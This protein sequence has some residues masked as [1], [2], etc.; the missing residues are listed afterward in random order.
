[1]GPRLGAVAV[2]V[3]LD[4]MGS[5]G[6]W[7]TASLAA[8]F[9][10]GPLAPALILFLGLAQTTYAAFVAGCIAKM[11]YV[12]YGLA[13]GVIGLVI[14]LSLELKPDD[15]LPGW[16]NAAFYLFTVPVGALGGYMAEGLRRLDG[17]A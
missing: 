13:V 2:G 8:Q 14:A 5:G 1:M 12:S 3:F 15:N 7:L 17:A 11:H 10:F 6:V 4:V 16:V 9:D